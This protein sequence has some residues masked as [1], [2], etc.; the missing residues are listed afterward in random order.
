MTSNDSTQS[1]LFE[2]VWVF[3]WGR[4]LKPVKQLLGD[5]FNECSEIAKHHTGST[6]GIASILQKLSLIYY[7]DVRKQALLSFLSALGAAIVGMLFFLYAAW[8]SMSAHAID[9]SA[10]ISLWAGGLTQFISAVNFYLYF[11]VARQFATFHVCLERMNRF[12]L[13]NTICDSLSGKKDEVRATLAQ[14][15][16]NAEMLSL[17]PSVEPTPK[18]SS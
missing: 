11:K 10:R 12:L 3:L 15:I 6:Q 17:D 2:R 1:G 16:A 8:H 14:I 4:S 7:L 18:P 5:V 13:A 9:E